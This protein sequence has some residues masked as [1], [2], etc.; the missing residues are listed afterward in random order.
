MSGQAKKPRPTPEEVRK[1]A[2]AGAS[3]RDMADACGVTATTLRNWFEEP[4]SGDLRRAFREGRGTR[5]AS[6]LDELGSLDKGQ[7]TSVRAK[8]LFRLLDEIEREHERERKRE[9]AP[10]ADDRRLDVTITTKTKPE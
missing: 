10:S 9:G 4:E 2:A 3:M 8:V 5:K 7:P 1:L 6:L